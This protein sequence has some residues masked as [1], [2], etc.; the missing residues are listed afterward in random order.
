M[1]RCQPPVPGGEGAR[2]ESPG[3]RQVGLRTWVSVVG[4]V[5]LLTIYLYQGNHRFFVER[6]AFLAP[7]HPLYEWTVQGYQ[8]GAA[9]LLLAV[10]P[11]L[12]M[13]LGLKLPPIRTLLSPGDWR[14]GLKFVVVAVPL[15]ALPLY[16]G[17]GS[18]EL[19][20]E[21]P[22]VKA[23]GLSA[24]HF[25]IWA[26]CYLVYYLAW[27]LFFR[28]FWQL[29]LQRELGVFAALALQ[30]TASTLMHIGKPQS[31]TLLAVAGGVVLGL[32]AIRSRSVLYGL[33]VHWYV[34]VATDL[35]CLLRSQ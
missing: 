30:T 19:Q 23:A 15:L 7:E 5:V 9:F 14:F 16:L 26:L 13:G 3:L 28:G 20:A 17:A 22:L 11:G 18:P 29:G 34:G 6:L 31:E 21:Y 4:G 27:E 25:A 33:A 8:I 10:L 1:R 32:V 12:W 35:F 2:P 24:G